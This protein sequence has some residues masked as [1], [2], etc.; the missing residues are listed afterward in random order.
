MRGD[1]SFLAKLGLGTVLLDFA[2]VLKLIVFFH[3]DE[4]LLGMGSDLSAGSGLDEV[5]YFFPV[6]S[7]EFKAIEELFVLF[8][9]PSS[10]SP[11]LVEV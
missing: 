3:F 11:G 8:L 1:M 6:F 5:F 2:L 7:V 10:S 9:G 4:E